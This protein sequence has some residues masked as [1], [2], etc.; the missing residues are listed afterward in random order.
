MKNIT[1][2]ILALLSVNAQANI[3]TNND[4]VVCHFT[5]PFVVSTYLVAE[6]T[7]SYSELVGPNGDEQVTT[8]AD[9]TLEWTQADKSFNLVS[10]TGEVL[11]SIT[12]TGKGSDGMSD[13]VYP[14]DVQDTKM[15]QNAN[16]GLGGCSSKLNPRI[17]GEDS[18]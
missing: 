2:A 1:L 8:I 7:L 9:V 4:E 3:L 11:Q 12:L 17:E 10:S 16:G 6:Q 5:E 15:I 14:F 13:I 18:Y